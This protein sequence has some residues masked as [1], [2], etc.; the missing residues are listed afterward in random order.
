LGSIFHKRSLRLFEGMN[1]HHFLMEAREKQ[2][3]LRNCGQI[4]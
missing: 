3:S 4:E 2:E 1:D